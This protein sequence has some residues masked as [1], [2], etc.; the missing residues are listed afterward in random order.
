MKNVI[1]FCRNRTCCPVVEFED[2]K[3]ILGDKDGPEGITQWSLSQFK[4]FVESVK[5]G[6]FDELLNEKGN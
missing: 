4:D 2:D 6:K 3:V 5:E 1:T